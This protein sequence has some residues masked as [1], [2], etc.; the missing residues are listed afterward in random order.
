MHSHSRGR[1]R[2]SEEPEPCE[3]SNAEPGN[4]EAEEK[5]E[6]GSYTARRQRKSPEEEE[7]LEM[8]HFWKIINTF[9]CY[10]SHIHERVSRAERQFMSLPKSQQNM[11][12][13]FHSNLDRIRKC[14][15][16][17][18]EIL[19]LIVNDCTCM[20]ENK[21]YGN[22]G[23]TKNTPASTF[24]MD[25]LKST[26]KQFVRDWSEEG[27]LEREVCYQPIINEILK[28]FPKD[29]CTDPSEI[30]VLVPGAGLGRLAWEIAMHGYS[31]QGNEWSFFMLF[32][33]NFVLNRCSQINAFKLYPWIH[34]FSNNMKSVDQVR[35][36][37]FPDVNPHDL[38]YNPN[39]SMTAG[40]FQE[41]YTENN[42]WDC[43]ATCFFID[44]A[45][46]ILDYIETIRKI[47]K[48]GGIWINLGPLLYHFENLANELSIE[49][50]YEDLKNVIIQHGFLI[51]VERESVRT[52]YTVNH[53]SMMKYF[54]DCI[55]FVAR[56]PE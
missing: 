28:Y 2:D 49:V 56:K 54:Y 35:P 40:D 10:G 9:T 44:T 34:Q 7:R 3:C 23:H 39:F 21:E 19:Q 52:T 13:N 30:N 25:K 46:N 48:P 38:P 16:H 47:L 20:F 36:V 15:D 22:N 41:I 37:Y 5:E 42:S 29:K 4:G 12:P 53:F 51:E 43:V 6:F 17:N 8:E 27:K 11:L 26:I 45:H 32:S 14:A 1:R 31:C 18:Q 50:S 55:F 24:D 33:S